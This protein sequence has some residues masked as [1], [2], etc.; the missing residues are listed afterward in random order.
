MSRSTKASQ[1]HTQYVCVRARACA[2]VE[3]NND[4]RTLRQVLH[5]RGD[6]RQVVQVTV[7]PVGNGYTE[8][9]PDYVH[10]W[11]G[12]PMALLAS[13]VSRQGARV[14]V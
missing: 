10:R 11:L 9:R 12:T 6:V 7:S 13:Q 5:G 8:P 2:G 1:R 3:W 4:A 14:T